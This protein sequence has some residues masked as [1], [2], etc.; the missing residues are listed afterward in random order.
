LKPD[1]FRALVK[2][3]AAKIQYPLCLK[4]IEGNMH[5]D[6]H[7]LARATLIY[8]LPSQIVGLK[9]KEERREAINSI[10]EIADP[11]HTKQFIMHGVKVLWKNANKAK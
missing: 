10:P 2:N 5:K 3:A 4:Y 1:R 6:F 7:A 9:T 11:I 8:Y